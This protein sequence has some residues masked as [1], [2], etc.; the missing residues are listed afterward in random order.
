MYKYT[1]IYN[2]RWMTGSHWH[3]STQMKRI[4]LAN[5]HNLCEQISNIIESENIIFLFEGW[6]L[7]VDE[8]PKD[9]N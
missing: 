3:T 1:V 4:E 2:K 6:P 8:T 5:T 7:M 9:V